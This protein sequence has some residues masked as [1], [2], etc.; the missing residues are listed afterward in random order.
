MVIEAK[1]KD[2]RGNGTAG[3]PGAR[4]DERRGRRQHPR[5][6]A[7]RPGHHR[8]AGAVRSR[9]DPR[10]RD[11]LLG[12]FIACLETKVGAAPAAEPEPTATPAA[13][14]AADSPAQAS[15]DAA[16]ATGTAKAKQESAPPGPV[17][18][19]PPA[20]SAPSHATDPAGDD[21]LDLGATVLPILIKGYWRE[22]LI[23][24]LAVLLVWRWVRD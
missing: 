9:C 12:Q 11:K 24:L 19:A 3:A 5:A 17:T 16:Q 22:G 15:A 2:K 13:T 21:A 20:P 18:A 6:G 8:Q 23:G 14:P 7:H 1:G 10:R 4:H